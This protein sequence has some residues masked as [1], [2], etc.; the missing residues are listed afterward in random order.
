MPVPLI[1]A[2]SGTSSTSS[3]SSYLQTAL[4]SQGHVP[5][6]VSNTLGTQWSQSATYDRWLRL[7]VLLGLICPTISTAH[8]VYL[9]NTVA[10]QV[11]GSHVFMLCIQTLTERYFR[12]RG[13]TPL[14]IR[15]LIPLLYNAARMGV[16]YHWMK[17]GV[18]GHFHTWEKLLGVL[19]WLHWPMN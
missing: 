11:V 6:L 2:S 16:L 14:P 15:I 18:A 10:G 17:M 4:T 8:Y 5:S 19:N 12:M 3:S 7:G 13:V 9:Q 1:H